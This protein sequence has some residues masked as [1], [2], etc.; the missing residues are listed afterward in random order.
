MEWK[1]DPN[2]S[3][4]GNKLRK[5]LHLLITMFSQLTL[6]SFRIFFVYFAPWNTPFQWNNITQEIEI[7]T[8]KFQLQRWRLV[9]V[10]QF[11]YALFIFIRFY[12]SFSYETSLHTHILQIPRLIAYVCMISAELTIFLFNTE[13]VFLFNQMRRNNQSFDPTQIPKKWDRLAIVTVYLLFSALSLPCFFGCFFYFNRHIPSF[14]YSVF[15]TSIE[16]DCV[17]VFLLFLCLEAVSIYCICGSCGCTFFIVCSF[18]IHSSYWMRTDET[19]LASRN[20]FSGYRKYQIL[21]L[22]TSRFNATFSNTFLA[23]FKEFLS[24]GFVLCSF[25][26]IR[27]HSELEFGS[28]LIL[29]AFSPASVIALAQIYLPAGWV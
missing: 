24:I 20:T 10:F 6:T 5:Q 9:S 16:S 4:K 28:L 8:N 22:H 21:R 3:Q 23:P 26:L 25:C 17:S 7:T 18:F 27:Y 13:I 14:L 29:S 11:L 12:Q 1:I 2:R 15:S 19:N